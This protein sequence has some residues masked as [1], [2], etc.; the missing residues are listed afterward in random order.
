M[1]A[2]FLSGQNLTAQFTSISIGSGKGT[3]SP[4][5]LV[6]FPSPQS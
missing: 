6:I 1:S 4:V 2:F 5:L 3:L